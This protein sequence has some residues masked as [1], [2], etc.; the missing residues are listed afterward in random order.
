MGA[1]GRLTPLSLFSLEAETERV[2][3][4]A[5]DLARRRHR[6]PPLRVAVPSPNLHRTIPTSPTAT[7]P[8]PEP[9]QLL[10]SG[11][12]RG[13]RGATARPPPAASDPARLRPRLH[14]PQPRP[15]RP[16]LASPPRP[17]PPAASDLARHP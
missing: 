10:L 4:T 17:P 1:S 7:Q 15:R 12:S 6:P 13:G 16:P 9:R 11:S 14:A 3:R 2:D 8:W 5:S